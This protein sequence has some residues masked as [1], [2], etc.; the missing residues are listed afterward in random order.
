MYKDYLRTL[1][2]NGDKVR[3]HWW[4]FPDSY[5]QWLSQAEIEG[6]PEPPREPNGAWRVTERFL[7]DLVKYN[8]WM[9][10][11]DYE[12]DDVEED[13]DSAAAASRHDSKGDTSDDTEDDV[14][15][16]NNN[17]KRKPDS[18]PSF[19]KPAK[20]SKFWKRR[21]VFG[22]TS[23]KSSIA[24][25]LEGPSGWPT[26]NPKGEQQG[27]RLVHTGGPLDSEE[28]QAHAQQSNA[29]FPF[30]AANV[31]WSNISNPQ[32][33][34]SAYFPYS[35]PLLAQVYTETKLRQ[36]AATSTETTTATTGV[37]TGASTTTTTATT[38]T[39]STATTTAAPN[40]T[41]ASQANQAS[42]PQATDSDSS[43]AQGTQS[44]SSGVDAKNAISTDDTKPVINQ[45]DTKTNTDNTATPTPRPL[46]IPKANQ[47]L[48]PHAQWFDP[49]MVHPH[50]KKAMHEY[51]ARRSKKKLDM[52]LKL[53]NF[54]VETYAQKPYRRLTLERCLEL[55][56]G[57]SHVTARIHRFLEL[58]GI[59]NHNLTTV[60]QLNYDGDLNHGYPILA[61]ARYDSLR[62]NKRQ[63]KGSNLPSASCSSLPYAG[64]G[65]GA[66][67]GGGSRA[68]FAEGEGLDEG[69]S[70]SEGMQTPDERISGGGVGSVDPRGE[71]K[72][73]K[74]RRTTRGFTK[75][76]M[77]DRNRAGS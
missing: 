62:L 53:R 4:Y 75:A 18:S 7:H 16:A 24:P 64:A 35:A 73:S 11:L 10:E 68:L 46:S 19:A 13:N 71:H 39:N 67:P 55:V 40:N 25:V 49:E 50:E 74:R 70:S 51:F 59:I 41:H 20:I 9:N 54:I 61:P 6:K 72:S 29:S 3:V 69:K 23:S 52:Y 2:I 38:A 27:I 32:V 43:K 48:P 66:V 44:S 15:I 12:E 5:D 21:E 8:E 65:A 58:W 17:R 56:D 1:E 76:A 42:G 45:T 14:P 30:P 77:G 37:T 47:I 26:S 60:N 36:A 33:Q 28:V 22:D 31:T 34:E 57:D 63:K